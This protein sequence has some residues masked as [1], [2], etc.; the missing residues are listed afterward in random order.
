MLTVNALNS[1]IGDFQ[2]NY[3]YKLNIVSYPAGVTA[4]FPSAATFV[5]DAD[6]YGSKLNIPESSTN[7]IEVKWSGMRAWFAGPQNPSGSVDLT[8]RCDRSYNALDFFLAWKNLTGDDTT[9]VA[10]VKGA[11]LGVLDI[12]MIDVDKTTVLKRTSLGAC[13]VMKVAQIEL[14]KAGE[15]LVEITIT[16]QYETKQTFAGSGVV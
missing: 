11:C 7:P 12:L 8:F 13:Q 10:A 3:L 5:A 2:R 16:V 9:G 1:T 4:A 15:A 14:D 6:L